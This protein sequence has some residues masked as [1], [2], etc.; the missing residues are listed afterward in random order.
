MQTART[1]DLASIRSI[2]RELEASLSVTALR[3]IARIKESKRADDV[4]IVIAPARLAVIRCVDI[5]SD[6]DHTAIAT[7]ISQG[8]FIWGAIV[9]SESAE[10]DPLGLIES[11]HV[12]RLD[13][14]VSR[15][16]ELREAFYEAG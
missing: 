2:T 13:Q 8:D 3:V 10:P 5:A 15:L 4:A 11:F 9:Y 6:E 14:L 7:M 16:S 1:E 12:D